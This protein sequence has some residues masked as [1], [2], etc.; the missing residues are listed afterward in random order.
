MKFRLP[1]DLPVQCPRCGV[2]TETVES[3]QP[4]DGTVELNCGCTM[5]SHDLT[6]AWA[7]P[8]PRAREER[9][10]SE[11]T[12]EEWRVTGEPGRGYPPYRFT[13]TA[14]ADSYGSQCPDPESAARSFVEAVRDW[15]NGPHLHRR[16][17]TRT[18]WE[19]A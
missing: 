13:W 12:F 17:V 15:D 11:T 3:A 19:P 1:S 14:D 5:P 2:P 10:V 9:P 8:A 16:T 7:I 6:V 18:E 4:Y